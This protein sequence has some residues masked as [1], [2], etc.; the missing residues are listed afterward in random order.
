MST[1]VWPLAG[2]YP[3]MSRKTRRLQYLASQLFFNLLQI[4][5]IRE[6]LATA[7]MLTLMGLF[8]CMRPDVNCQGT[9]LNEALPAS[10]CQA[11]VGP[12][13]GVY[14]EMSLQI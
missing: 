7:N 5:Y 13:V 9:S 14:S 4:T 3:A 12:L 11:G 2:M 10:W 1:F 8:A 6:P